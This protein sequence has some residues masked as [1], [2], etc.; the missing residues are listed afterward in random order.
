MAPQAGTSKSECLPFAGNQRDHDNRK[1]RLVPPLAVCAPET[2]RLAHALNDP[3]GCRIPDRNVDVLT[4]E[5]A[6][7]QRVIDLLKAPTSAA[8]REQ[9]FIFTSLVMAMRWNTALRSRL[10]IPPSETSQQPR[11]PAMISAKS[12]LHARPGV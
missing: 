8:T 6:T 4:N 1:P 3:G 11:S 12:L 9:I 7:R 5:R 2:E 10:M